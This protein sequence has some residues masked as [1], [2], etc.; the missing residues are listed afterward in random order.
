MTFKEALHLVSTDVVLR[1]IFPNWAMGLT[2]KLRKVRLAFEELNVRIKYYCMLV[3]LAEI[4]ISNTCWIWSKSVK[5]QTSRQKDM[6]SSAVSW[7][8]TKTKISRMVKVAYRLRNFLVRA[9]HVITLAMHLPIQ[10]IGNIFIF[11]LAGHEVRIYHILTPVSSSTK[12]LHY[13]QHRI[14][15]VLLSGC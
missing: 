4:N 6:I 9:L 12:S 11:Q 7:T 8:Q 10:S 2:K 13:R 14:P 3:S 15:F 1:L 5:H